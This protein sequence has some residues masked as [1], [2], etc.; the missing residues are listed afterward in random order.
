MKIS[1]KKYAQALLEAIGEKKVSE[2]K[3]VIKKFVEIMQANNNLSQINKVIEQFNKLW[4]KKQGIIEAEI[5]SAKELDKEIVKL[6]NS[7][8]IKLTGAKEAILNKKVD[9][10][11]LGGVIIKYKD[12]IIDG[13][14]RNKLDELKIKM[15]K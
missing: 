2:I 13:S 4:N 12:I 7:Y 10:N 5:I 14:L 11:I 1:P 8:I 3:E 15:I 9:K 6:L